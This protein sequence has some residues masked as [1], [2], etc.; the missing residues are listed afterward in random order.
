VSCR[1]SGTYGYSLG[2]GKFGSSV[3]ASFV[4]QEQTAVQSRRSLAGSTGKPI[5]REAQLRRVVLAAEHFKRDRSR[6]SIEFGR[7]SGEMRG[8]TS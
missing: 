2:R 1:A 5:D 4:A 3:A 6:G 7:P 8:L